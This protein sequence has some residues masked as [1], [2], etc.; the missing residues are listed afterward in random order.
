MSERFPLD[1]LRLR[2]PHDLRARSRPLARRFAESVRR[3]AGNAPAL[4]IDLGAG[5]GSGF[6]AIAPLVASDQDWRLVENDPALLAVQA[7]EIAQWAR[8]QGYPARLGSGVATIDLDAARWQAHSVAHDLAGRLDALP[9]IGAHGVTASALLD[10][11]S[12]D[13]LA[14]LIARIAGLPFLA[15]VTVDGRRVW[16][17]ANPDDALVEALFARHQRGDKGFGPALGPAASAEAASLLRR[18]GY[19]VESA[20]GDWRLGAGDDTVLEMM[21][22]GAADAARAVDADVGDRIER[23][24]ATRHAARIEGALRLAVG[25]VDILALPDETC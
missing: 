24:R 16:E 12:L 6:R 14:R 18:A 11:V 23:W 17:P 20:A 10:L 4:V 8:G 25:H 2:E 9:M 22:D 3:R 19:R 7:A 15:A 5:S 13:W 1:W 21:I